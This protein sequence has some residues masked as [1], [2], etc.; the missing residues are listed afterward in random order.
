MS[1]SISLWK[2]LITKKLM[3]ILCVVFLLLSIV[4]LGYLSENS[5]PSVLQSHVAITNKA[6]VDRLAGVPSRLKPV[7]EQSEKWIVITTLSAP[8]SDVKFLASLS[9]WKVVVVADVATP[10][11]WNYPNCVFLDM[12][13]QKKLNY[14]TT[15]FIPE[16]SYARKNIGYLY[17]IQHGAKIIY[18]TDDDNRPLFGLKRFDYGSTFAGLEFAGRD[19]FNPYHHFGQSTLWPRGFPLSAIGQAS[20]RLYRMYQNMK[21]PSIQQGVVNGDPD[22]DAIFRLTRKRVDRR[23]DV[24]FDSVAPA[25]AL[26]AGTFSPFNSQNT[27]F[28]E[29]AFWALL[30]PTATTMRV[31]DIWRGY[32][33]QRLLWE[34]GGTLAFYPPN[35]YQQRN[36]HSYLLDAMDELALYT[37]TE[38]L[39]T[40]LRQWVCHPR[41]SFYGCVEALT[42]DMVSAKL[43]SARDLEVTQAWLIDL[44]RVGYRE[45]IRKPVAWSSPNKKIHDVITGKQSIK[46]C[47]GRPNYPASFTVYNSSFVIFYPKEQILPPLQSKDFSPMP[48][49]LQHLMMTDQICSDSHLPLNLNDLSL[50]GQGVDFFNDILVVV[51]FHYSDF[52]QNILYLEAAYRTIFPN[53][54][55]CGP[56]RV[57]FQA[58]MDSL[59]YKRRVSFIEADVSCGYLAY[60]C[61]LEAMRTGYNVTGYLHISDD[62]LINPWAFTGMNKS[63]VWATKSRHYTLDTF[64]FEKNWEWWRRPVGETAFRHAVQDIFTSDRPAEVRP[65]QKMLSSLEDAADRPGMIMRGLSD[66]YFIPRRLQE[67]VSWYFSKFQQNSVFLE[68]A[69]PVVLYG[70]EPASDIESISGLSI[71]GDQRSKMWSFYDPDSHYLHPIKL[72]EKKWIHHFCST[73]LAT[74][75]KK[76]YSS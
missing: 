46:E 67:E 9:G 49:V 41:L 3:T 11:D 2:R 72:A 21:T 12:E 54:I 55:Y 43:W 24:H 47:E 44:E 61:V 69:V 42:F 62:V 23:L 66:A 70:L 63:R 6:R 26:P 73:F 56:N 1:L 10:T 19:L 30:I 53:L 60:S 13:Q 75:L 39:I 68:I 14:F 18:E 15:E 37:E 28:H 51:T 25:A 57:Q 64:G 33:A 16:K 76:L 58:A 32:W 48:K 7:A 17:A 27:L 22:M 4:T 59:S 36:N 45:P 20:D 5:T 65:W 71:E 8:T 40:F 29:D 34:I 35:A 74:M 31:C 38:T 52:Y 50:T